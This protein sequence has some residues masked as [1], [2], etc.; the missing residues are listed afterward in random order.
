[1]PLDFAA[2]KELEIAEESDGVSLKRRRDDEDDDK[3]LLTDEENDDDEGAE[4]DKEV[5]E[6][7]VETSKDSVD[8]KLKPSQYGSGIYAQRDI[9]RP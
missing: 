7:E 5:G 2:E 1:M 8:T 6:I 4:I 9:E 3:N